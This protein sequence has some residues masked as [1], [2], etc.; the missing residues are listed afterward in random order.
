[1]KTAWI[2]SGALAVFL[3]GCDTGE[4]AADGA[5]SDTHWADGANNVNGICS[6]HPYTCEDL[7]PEEE[8]LDARCC[9]DSSIYYCENGEVKLNSCS[10]GCAYSAELDRVYC[11]SPTGTGSGTQGPTGGDWPGTEPDPGG[12]I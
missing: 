10:N 2:L 11:L 9:F 8:W 7:V 5:D 1:M 6:S 4:S 12:G 3:T